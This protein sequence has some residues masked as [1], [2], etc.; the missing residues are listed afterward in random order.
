MKNPQKAQPDGAKQHSVMIVED[1]PLL[2][3]LLE[4]K[5]QQAGLKVFSATDVEQAK[6][7]L[8]NQPVNAIL[9][10]ILLPG[11]NGMTF[12]KELKADKGLKD[13]PVII[14]SN[15]GQEDEIKQGMEAGAVEYIVKANVTPGEI[16]GRVMKY[17]PKK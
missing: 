13:I 11:E 8:K 12:L 14:G 6:L 4:K 3:E 9:L 7:I 1:E 5:M 17:L 15:L 16:V 10:D 2:I